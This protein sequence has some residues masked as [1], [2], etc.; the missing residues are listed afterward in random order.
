MNVPIILYD[1]YCNLCNFST[2]LI[3]R[4]DRKSIFRYVP[5]QSPEG[6]KLLSGTEGIPDTVILSFNNTLYF[7]SDA[8][9]KTAWLLGFPANILA[10]FYIMPGFLRDYFYDLVARNR[11]RI[12]GKKD[13]CRMTPKKQKRRPKLWSPIKN[14]KNQ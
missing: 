1:G 9:L 10:V 4:F 14:I 3:L 2:R 5:L 6:Q 13:S 7:K 12:F 8:V 11:Y